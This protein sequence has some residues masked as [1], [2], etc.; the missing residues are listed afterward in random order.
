MTDCFVSNRREDGPRVRAIVQGLR[1]AGVE[2][3]WDRGI[4]GGERSVETV[5]E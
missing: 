2:V 3:A 4:S 1:D 5:A